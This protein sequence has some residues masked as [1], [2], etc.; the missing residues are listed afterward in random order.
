MYEKNKIRHM[1][2]PEK[3]KVCHEEKPPQLG[4]GATYLA[5]LASLSQWL[6]FT[7][8]WFVCISASQALY[9]SGDSGSTY[10]VRCRDRLAVAPSSSGFLM[11]SKFCQ[12]TAASSTRC[13]QTQ[14]RPHDSLRA[15]PLLV[16]L[17]ILISYASPASSAQLGRRTQHTVKRHVS[18]SCTWHTTRIVC[19]PPFSHQIVSPKPLLFWG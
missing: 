17:D 6:C 18:I 13:R 7:L 10:F 5:L 8:H 4:A 14:L 3:N 2:T 15:N 1:C 12:S 11:A 19:P 16:M 9:I